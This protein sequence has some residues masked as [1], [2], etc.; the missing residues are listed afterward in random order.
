MD[1]PA[2]ARGSQALR[3]IFTFCRK[4]SLSGTLGHKTTE[5]AF[6]GKPTPHPL[7]RG[8]SL[9][10]PLLERAVFSGF[11]SDKSKGC[12]RHGGAASCGRA[13]SAEVYKGMKLRGMEGIKQK[14]IPLVWQSP[15][16]EEFETFFLKRSN[17]PQTTVLAERVE[18]LMNNF[19]G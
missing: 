14:K 8:C 5:I 10:S 13:V 19:W 3:G 9:S 2:D 12:S 17:T 6:Y 11:D 18:D 7:P 16:K 15:S 4:G 1:I